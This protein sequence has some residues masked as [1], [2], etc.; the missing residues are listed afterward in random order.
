MDANASTQTKLIRL[1]ELLLFLGKHTE[2]ISRFPIAITIE[3]VWRG[4][5]RNEL[6]LT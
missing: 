3:N 6:I 1:Q 5:S 4:Y 2:K